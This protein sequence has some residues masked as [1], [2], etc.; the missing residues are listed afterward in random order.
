MADKREM[1]RAT[2]R[3]RRALARTAAGEKAKAVC[4]RVAS[5][6]NKARWVLAEKSFADILRSQGVQTLPRCLLLKNASIHV[7]GGNSVSDKDKLSEVSL[8]FAIAW[9][10][11]FPLFDNPAIAGHLEK[12]WPGFILELKDAFI[13][14][15]VEGPF[16]HTMSG[17]RGRRHGTNYHSGKRH[18]S[19]SH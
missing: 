12:T 11:L 6:V 7:I 16:P 9:T 3:Q 10:F 2:A 17:H 19:K 5:A 18:R 1:T 15:V 4:D 13:T 8:E 14:L